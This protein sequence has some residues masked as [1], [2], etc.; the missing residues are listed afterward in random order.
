MTSE[1]RLD[2]PPII[3]SDSGP[4][5]PLVTAIILNYKNYSE[6]I[7]CV[8]NVLCQEYPALACV[9][10]DNAS[11]NNSL[12]QIQKAI[13]ADVRVKVLA[14]ETNGGYGMG[15]NIGARWAL[16][17]Q[18]PR[19]LFVV[20]PDVRLSA[21]DTVSRLVEFASRTP[22]AGVVGPKVVLPNGFVQGPYKRPSLIVTCAQFLFPP[23]WL[24]LR[25]KR[26]R[27]L[28]RISQAQR[29]FRT[30]GACMLLDATSFAEAGMF[31]EAIFL[32]SEEPVLA[33]R[34]AIKSK[35]FYYF[36]D[37]TVVHYHAR[38]GGSTE[39]IKS[40]AYYF[41]TYRGAGESSIAVLRICAS[42]YGKIYEP[43]KRMIRF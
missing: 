8:A 37:V 26:Q 21:P 41:R 36:P 10:V 17:N 15:N 29:C 16:A 31:D 14:A 19:Y 25:V 2:R 39:T 32:E 4:N 42:L 12:S 18:N 13:G 27:D 5:T 9:V 33:E 23:L 1:N 22:D 20:N 24:I 40:L 7:E 3:G 35:Y 34:L 43:L 30:I 28:M 38:A 6:T 11:P